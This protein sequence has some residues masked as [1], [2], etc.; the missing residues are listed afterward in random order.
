MS[1]SLRS[2]VVIQADATPV[3]F[4]YGNAFISNGI[5]AWFPTVELRIDFKSRAAPNTTW[6]AQSTICRALVNGRHENDVEL[7]AEDGTLL[8]VAREMALIVPMA[9]NLRKG[10]KAAKL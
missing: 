4:R 10:K 9:V 7:W 6:I 3:A 8:A 1:R 2:R 5:Q